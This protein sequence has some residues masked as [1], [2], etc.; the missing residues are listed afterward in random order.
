MLK[1]IIMNRVAALL[2][3][4]LFFTLDALSPEDFRIKSLPYLD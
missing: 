4:S 3:L 1:I 2:L